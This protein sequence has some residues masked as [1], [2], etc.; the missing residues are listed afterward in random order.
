MY[1]LRVAYLVNQNVQSRA[2]SC[3]VILLHPCHDDLVISVKTTGN[4]IPA[5]SDVATA[6]CIPAAALEYWS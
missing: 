2:T 5:L 1:Q 3:H 6:S 4:S